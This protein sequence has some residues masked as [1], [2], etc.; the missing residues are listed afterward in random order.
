MASQNCFNP[1]HRLDV[2]SPDGLYRSSG[3]D[4][5]I[6]ELNGTHKMQGVLG[7]EITRPNAI[8]RI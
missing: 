6:R 2:G 3:F 8:F 5:Q 7:A 1:R 4:R